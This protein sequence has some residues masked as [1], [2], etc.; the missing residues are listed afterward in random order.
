MADIDAIAAHARLASLP[1]VRHSRTERDAS[2]SARQRAETAERIRRTRLDNAG[3]Y[4]AGK[5]EQFG[6]GAQK[7]RGAKHALAG[8]SQR[9]RI[10]EALRKGPMTAAEICER[11]HAT[12]ATQRIADLRD[13]GHEIVT[14]R[15]ETERG[16]AHRY[17]LVKEKR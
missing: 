10:L 2:E 15:V 14:E 9:E 8:K 6:Q 17:R 3:T 7:A 1:T 16:A 11:F 13:A 12:R 4:N 5:P